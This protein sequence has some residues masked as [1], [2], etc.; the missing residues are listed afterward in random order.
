M[1]TVYLLVTGLLAALIA[2]A[3]CGPSAKAS[4]Q[5]RAEPI[6]R[7]TRRP[8]EDRRT[9]GDVQHGKGTWYGK[10]WHGK[11]TAS[12]ERFD[13]WSMTAAHRTLPMG[14]IV[15]VTNEK[16]GRSV[17][18]RINNRGPYGKGRIIDVSEAAARKLD[19]IDAGVVPVTIEVVSTPP[20]KSKKRR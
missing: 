9:H 14:S 12:G 7:R 17:K 18:V 2:A 19:M 13:R 4:T 20:K 10:D 3:A 6:E 5:A 1:R 15:R 8:A 11:P 16:N